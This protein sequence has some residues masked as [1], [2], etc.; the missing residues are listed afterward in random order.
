MTVQ[1][2]TSTILEDGSDET[3]VGSGAGQGQYLVTWMKTDAEVGKKIIAEQ[4][5]FFQDPKEEDCFFFFLVSSPNAGWGGGAATQHCLKHS[6]PSLRKNSSE[7]TNMD[8]VQQHGY[9]PLN[10]LRVQAKF[11]RPKEITPQGSM[12]AGYNL[13]QFYYWLGLN[14]PYTASKSKKISG[15]FSAGRKHR[16]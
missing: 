9:S 16:F 4:I 1:I 13:L 12:V 7:V 10:H 11:M 5:S 3:L 8:S 6:W 14:T 2:V 15:T